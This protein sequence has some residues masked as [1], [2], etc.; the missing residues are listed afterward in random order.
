MSDGTTE[1]I[2]K[3]FSGPIKLGE[4]YN[5]TNGTRIAFDNAGLIVGKTEIPND[6]S[7]VF[8]GDDGKVELGAFIRTFK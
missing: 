4:T 1:Q 5:L 6:T 8:I 2:G 7:N 3:H